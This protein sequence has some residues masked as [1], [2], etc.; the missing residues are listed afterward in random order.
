M[1]FSSG[2]QVG[3]KTSY[4]TIDNKIGN[5]YIYTYICAYVEIYRL[6]TGCVLYCLAEGYMYKYIYD[7]YHLVPEPKKKQLISVKCK[8]EL[9]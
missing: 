8:H 7:P 4:I 5:I 6:Y 9:L 2:K 3:G 1:D